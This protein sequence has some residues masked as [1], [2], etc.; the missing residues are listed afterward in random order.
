MKVICLDFQLA[1]SHVVLKSEVCIRDD[2]APGS[3][4]WCL[5]DCTDEGHLFL[6]MCCVCPLSP[7]AAA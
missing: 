4:S 3:S 7:S 6:G 2:T 5:K 1:A